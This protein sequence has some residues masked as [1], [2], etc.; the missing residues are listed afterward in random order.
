MMVMDVSADDGR[1]LRGLGPNAATMQAAM[2]AAGPGPAIGYSV[3]FL[4]A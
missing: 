4:L 1:P 2:E 3:A